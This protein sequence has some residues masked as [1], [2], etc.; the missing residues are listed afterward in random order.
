MFASGDSPEISCFHGQI[1]TVNDQVQQPGLV[2][3][4]SDYVWLK[5]TRQ[6]THTGAEVLAKGKG[7]HQL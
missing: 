7:R 5:V 2:I 1:I 3:R 6:V 4:G